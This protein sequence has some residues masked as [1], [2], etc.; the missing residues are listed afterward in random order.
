VSGRYVIFVRAVFVALVLATTP[1][2]AANLI[3]N[4]YAES[5]ARDEMTAI[6][7]RYIA[8]GE[9]AINAAVTALQKLDRDKVF[10]CSGEDRL[11]YQQAMSELGFVSSIGL[12]DRTGVRMCAVP[13]QA[14]N[15]QAI[16]PVR[17][18]D[19]PLVGI[20]MLDK[21]FL[22]ANAAIVSWQLK[23]GNRMFAEIAPAAIAIDPGPEYLMAYRRAE[24]RLGNNIVWLTTGGYTSQANDSSDTIL[25]DVHSERYPLRASVVVPTAAAVNLVQGLKMVTAM[26]CAGFAVLF[27]AI[28]VWFSWR[29]ENEAD[30]EFQA[31]IRHGEFIPYYQP[32]MDI[33]T[34]RL[35]GCEVL[36]RWRRSDGT[37]VSPGQFMA[38]AEASGHIFAMTRN[39]MKITCEEV[40]D[41]YRDNPELKLSVNL[42]A[43]HFDNRDVVT[44]I[45][46]IYENSKISFQQLV[47]EVTERYPLEDLEL[48][49]KII[50]ELQA[51]GVRI[52]LDD[53][54]TGHGG[55][56]YLQK[57]GVDIIKID[58]MFIDALGSD[59]SSTTIV[60]SM[61]ELADNLGMGIIAE[62]V[63]Q[64]T[65]IEKLREL[66]VTAAQGYIFAPPLPAKAYIELADK[67]A[68][69]E[70]EAALAEEESNE[71][72]EALE[73]MGDLDELPGEEA[74]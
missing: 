7:H 37:M 72:M 14:D 57:L 71:L 42:F 32:V 29:P 4:H 74:A 73:E 21:N 53:V 68:A 1:L 66:G 49:R 35:R 2:L 58:K 63:E 23:N 15:G 40:G 11:I 19:A 55:M 8:R 45:K 52:A 5:H 39:M 30:D 9:N 43:G 54:G 65:Q 59:D 3:L 50:A 56:A 60:D 67:L 61:V 69:E 34:G 62:G 38:Y 26:A 41:L 22:G 31:A 48:A 33:E 64:E 46:E 13:E 28:G 10:T 27:V 18:S 70:M 44:D 20:G 51:L 25:V 24:L 12:V 47:V 6:A 17:K 16:L 36:M